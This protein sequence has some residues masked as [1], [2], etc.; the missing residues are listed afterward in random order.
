[1]CNKE[2]RILI[3]AFFVHQLPPLPFLHA[4]S[5]PLVQ[6][7]LVGEQ[8]MKVNEA[9]W[10]LKAKGKREVRM[11][12]LKGVAVSWALVYLAKTREFHL[13]VAVQAVT[14]ERK[15]LSNNNKKKKIN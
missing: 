5:P 11:Q 10:P 13:R 9:C 15:Q 8:A 4:C 12:T 7:A 2:K 14:R 6:E 1:M 3:T